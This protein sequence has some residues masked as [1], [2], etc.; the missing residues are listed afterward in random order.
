LPYEAAWLP[1]QRIYVPVRGGIADSW[2]AA[3]IRAAGMYLLIDVGEV[4]GEKF[5]DVYFV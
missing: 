3:L 4:A 2:P 5:S 1:I